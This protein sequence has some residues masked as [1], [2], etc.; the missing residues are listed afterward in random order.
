MA[1]GRY[2]ELQESVNTL[3]RQVAADQANLK[4]LQGQILAS[5]T[6]L[7]RLQAEVAEAAKRIDRMKHEYPV[8]NLSQYVSAAYDLQRLQVALENCEQHIAGLSVREDIVRDSLAD[9]E[10][11]LKV[12]HSELLTYGWLVEFKR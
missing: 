6:D 12:V 8:V 7:K 2:A 10:G 1:S 4:R 9:I 5:R 11:N 3:N